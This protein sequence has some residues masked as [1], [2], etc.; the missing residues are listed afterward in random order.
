MQKKISKSTVLKSIVFYI[1]NTI[2][3]CYESIIYTN[4]DNIYDNYTIQ[5]VNYTYLFEKHYLHLRRCLIIKY[6]IYE[7]K[8]LFIANL[9]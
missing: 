3:S 8:S 1:F 7:N 5:F 6:G 2:I 9:L 4:F